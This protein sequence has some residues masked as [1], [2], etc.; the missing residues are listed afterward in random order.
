MILLVS[1]LVSIAPLPG[2]VHLHRPSVVDEYARAHPRRRSAT[3][4]P[5][6]PARSSTGAD[7]TQGPSLEVD[8]GGALRFNYLYRDYRP[9]DAVEVGQLLFDTFRVE[10]DGRYGPIRFGVEYRLYAGFHMLKTGWVGY[11]LGDGVLLQAGVHQVPFG[12][13]TYASNSWFFQLPYYVGLEDDH[14]AGL[15]V[16]WKRGPL[17]LAAAFYKQYDGPFSGQSRASAR[18]SYD[19]VPI[20]DGALDY[21]SAPV[22]GVRSNREVN[23]GNVAATYTLGDGDVTAEVGASAQ[24]GGLYNEVTEKVG[25]HWAIAG[26]VNAKAGPLGAKLQVIR[27]AHDPRNPAGQ[28]TDFVVFGAYDLPYKVTADGTFHSA[29]LSYAVPTDAPVISSLTVYNDVSVLDK[30][31]ATFI[32]SVQNI[33]GVS[34]GAGPLFTYVDL[35]VARNH[36][37]AIAGEDF[38]A[39][40]AEGAREWHVRFNINLGIYF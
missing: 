27:F 25:T 30:G 23:Q 17:R 14:D 6:P 13:T 15:K 26:H 4:A 34:V 1:A 20:A 9:A 33:T 5:P 12:I 38:A 3:E 24:L 7:T 40:L 21:G 37:F 11:E 28:A 19:V 10:A 31:P 29:A 22:A 16:T 32:D 39:A 36:P 18:Y 8:V 35:V 2:D